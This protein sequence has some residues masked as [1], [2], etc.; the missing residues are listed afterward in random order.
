[1]WTLLRTLS[2]PLGSSLAGAITGLATSQASPVRRA[3]AQVGFS[4]G[5]VLCK[6][7]L[8]FKCHL[9]SGS[10]LTYGM[11]SFR[12]DPWVKLSG[13]VGHL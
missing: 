7:A 3:T 5:Q 6:E 13:R 9:P 11:S 4:S 12:N 1:M 8:C 2:G 10:V